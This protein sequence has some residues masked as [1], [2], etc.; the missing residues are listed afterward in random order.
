MGT[1]FSMDKKGA[2]QTQEPNN[3]AYSTRLLRKN[4]WSI[5]HSFLL[6]RDELKFNE[7][8]KNLKKFE[9]K[10]KSISGENRY[11][12]YSAM[13]CRIFQ[14]LEAKKIVAESDRSVVTALYCA[15][16]N[17]DVEIEAGADLNKICKENNKLKGKN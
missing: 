5:V 11:K 4:T 2:V 14:H 12:T 13:N 17:N 10:Y 3:S 16:Y 15:T 1:A 9:T 8:Q 6:P 7:M